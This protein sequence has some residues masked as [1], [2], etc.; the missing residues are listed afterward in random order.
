MLDHVLVEGARRKRYVS[1][2]I[3]L[4]IG[5]FLISTA[6]TSAETPVADLVPVLAPPVELVPTQVPGQATQGGIL[7]DTKWKHELY[8]YAKTNVKH[9]IWGIAH[10]ERDYNLAIR[11]ASQEKLTV[12]KDVLFAAAF[13]H[14]IGA[15]EPFRIN[16][17]DHATRSAEIMEPLLKS[18][19]LSD[20]M[21]SNV[22]EAILAHMFNADV[23]P[24]G[25][26]T[27]VFHDADTLDFLGDVGVVRIAGL[28]DRH[29]WAPNLEGAIQ[30]LEV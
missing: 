4:T 14:D 23:A 12:D 7:L 15:I 29:R 17:V 20:A 28:S 13:L 30:T 24:K 25:N 9:S 19:G 1:E 26:E 8:E 3:I 22:R 10:S 18:Y 27:I 11:L 6:V 5:A 16:G 2:L 21:I